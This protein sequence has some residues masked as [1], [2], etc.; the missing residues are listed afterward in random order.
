MHAGQHTGLCSHPL[1][2]MREQEVAQS[3]AVPPSPYKRECDGR[4]GKGGAVCMHPL[5]NR[6]C[7]PPPPVATGWRGDNG[8]G[9]RAMED[10]RSPF[11]VPGL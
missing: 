10:A 3:V 9:E 11:F 4:K 8:K 1:P 5:M 2:A 7:A 6:R